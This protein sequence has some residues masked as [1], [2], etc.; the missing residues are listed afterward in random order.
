MGKKTPL[1]SQHHAAHAKMVDFSG[2]DMPLHYGSQIEEH[3][4][5]RRAAGMFDVSHMAILDL[6]GIN[7]RQFLQYLLANDVGRLEIP[8]KA[9][10]SCML[11]PA[12]CV[13]DDLIVYFI[14]EDWWRLVINC[15]TRTTDINWISEHA[16]VNNVSIQERTDL[17][18]IAIQGPLAQEK[19][20]PFIPQ[21]PPTLAPFRSIIFN[22]WFIS[23]TGYT[24]E[25][26]FEIM[27]PAQQAPELWEK[28]RSIGVAPCGLG[29][30]DTLRLEAGLNLYG[31]DMDESVTPLESGLSWTVAFSPRNRNFIG[32]TALELQ[33]QRGVTQ[34]L[35]G[36]I[37]SV[38]G[39]MRHGQNVIVPEIGTGIITSGG[40]SPT[41]E[42][43]IALARVPIATAHDCQIE[44][45]RQLLPAKII[46]PPFVRRGK[47]LLT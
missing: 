34:K 20:L 3:H 37:L 44:I 16:R 30:R 35:V 43:S 31:Q 4:S 22:D 15:A 23:R 26:G 17:A 46:S 29:A 7:C 9:I 12:G 5:V 18:I 27:L 47:S 28:L 32:R 13:L 38:P 33:H 36:L 41:L 24:G 1:Y 2:W 40:F 8:G 25:D 39:I 11:N 21:L 42:K 19:I 10:Y 6:H 14:R 45:R